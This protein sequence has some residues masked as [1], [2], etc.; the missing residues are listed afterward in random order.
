MDFRDWLIA[1]KQRHL[2]AIERID[3]QL[4][5][6]GDGLPTLPDRTPAAIRAL[7]AM[8]GKPMTPGEVVEALREHGRN[9][10]PNAAYQALARLAK[11]GEIERC[12][13]GLYKTKT[14]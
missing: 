7:L 4:A 3:D 8:A 12:M 1:D 14:T 6:L 11:A 10:L 13:Q 5:S 2:A 9:T